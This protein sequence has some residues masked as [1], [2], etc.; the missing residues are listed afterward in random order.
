MS[1]ILPPHCLAAGAGRKILEGYKNFLDDFAGVLAEDIGDTES[2]VTYPHPWYGK[3]T[4][5]GWHCLAAFHQRAHR[6]Q[7][8]KIIAG[9]GRLATADVTISRRPFRTKH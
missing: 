2:K 3:L 9:L 8:E 6:H 4:A 1:S 5:H 7:M